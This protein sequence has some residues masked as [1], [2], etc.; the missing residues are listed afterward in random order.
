MAVGSSAAGPLA[1]LRDIV[2]DVKVTGQAGFSPTGDNVDLYAGD[3]VVVASEGE[4]LLDF[5]PTCQRLLEPN[6]SLVVRVDDGCACAGVFA[7]GQETATGAALPYVL[8]GALI[9]GGAATAILLSQDSD[10]EPT[11]P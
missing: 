4:A 3:S 2:G 10:S 1:Q 8:G 9:L 5:G 7:V 11:S 6:T